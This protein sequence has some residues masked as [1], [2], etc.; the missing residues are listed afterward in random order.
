MVVG[1]YEVVRPCHGVTV[2]AR[3][4]RL[5]GAGVNALMLQVT[6]RSIPRLHGG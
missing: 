5:W 6:A 2:V 4:S 1:K 3:A